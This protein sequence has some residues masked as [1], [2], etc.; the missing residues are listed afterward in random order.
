MLIKK[1]ED[2]NEE[3]IID[4]N[5][6]ANRDKT[7][8]FSNIKPGKPVSDLDDKDR[9]TAISS[10]IGTKTFKDSTFTKDKFR[11]TQEL[12]EDANNDKNMHS[13]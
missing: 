13:D 10:R 2:I 6:F 9:D 3:D 5:Q 8:L 7:C 12:E 11:F 1:V 4:Q